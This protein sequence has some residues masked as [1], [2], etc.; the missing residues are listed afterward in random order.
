MRAAV[1][2][3]AGWFL[4][5]APARGQQDIGHKTLGTLGLR[6][7]EQPDTGIYLTDAFGHYGATKLVDRHGDEIP[8][9]LDLGAL[10]GAFGIAGT[11]ELPKT[12]IF[13]GAAA[14]FPIAHVTVNTARPE[15]SI[16]GFG[17]GDA[18]V[19]PVKLGWRTQWT[20]LVASYA[21]YAPTGEFEPGGNDGVGRGNWTHQVSLG[22]TIAFDPKRRWTLSA[23]AS[24]DV[25][26]RKRNVDITRG[27]TLQVQGGLGYA[28]RRIVQLGVAAYALWQVTDDTGAD[29]PPVFRGARDVAYGLGPEVSLRLPPIHCSLTARYAHDFA[30]ESRPEGE[31]FF[32]ALT[33]V[34]WRRR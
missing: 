15:A 19:Q 2:V 27:A 8:V 21:F 9:G 14:S 29:L 26:M 33:T 28:P 13:V 34:L 18:Y 31:L 17:L 1:A 30:V 11:F 6:A 3:G 32:F 24:F 10:A 25:N 20:D 12:S 16:D 23:L 5:C 7:G 4:L 22:G